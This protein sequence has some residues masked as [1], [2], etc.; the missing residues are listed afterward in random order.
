MD[1]KTSAEA[2]KMSEIN[3]KNVAQKEYHHILGTSGYKGAK[4]KWDQTETD[5]L[6]KGIYPEPLEWPE[7]SKSWFYA[8]GGML[9]PETGK[10]IFT[11]EHLDK[12][13]KALK[14]AMKNVQEGKFHPDRE[15]GELTHALENPEHSGRT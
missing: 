10:C 7:R 9:Q 8:H 5:L 11:K 3:K 13:L 15:N 6:G 14:T 1:Y 2:K 4:P 12:P